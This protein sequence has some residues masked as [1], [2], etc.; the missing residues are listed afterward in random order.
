MTLRETAEKLR[1]L[2]NVAILTH[3]NP[4]GDC[5]GSA[6]AL[7]RMLRSLGKRAKVLC[8]DPVGDKFTRWMNSL[9]DVFT[10]ETYVSVDV[11]TPELLGNYHALGEEGKVVLCIDHHPTNSGYAHASY[12]DRFAAATAEIIFRLAKPL[13]VTIDKET[14]TALYI[15]VLTDTGCFQFSNTTPATHRIA[16]R[17][18]AL[19][20]PAE[21]LNRAFFG[22]KSRGRLALEA[23]ALDSLRYEAN[24]QVAIMTVTEE[25]RVKANVS[26]SDLDG[27]SALPRQ[28]EGVEIGIMLREKDENLW[29]VSVRTN[30]TADASALCATF[31]GGGHIRAAGCTVTG[32]LSDVIARLTEACEKELGYER[33]SLH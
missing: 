8:S 3:R 30:T 26:D 21:E 10:P 13:G 11:A 4:D 27:L 5:L 22:I 14:A 32:E 17:L 19:G 9:D 1:T 6:A 7:C 20:A 2:E 25:M 29:R 15:G 33:N 24:G 31:G 12:V 18:M 23:T 16:A 28:I